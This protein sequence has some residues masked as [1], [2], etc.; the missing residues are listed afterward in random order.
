METF[1]LDTTT[2]LSVAFVYA[3][4]MG[5]TEMVKRLLSNRITNLM[6]MLL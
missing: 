1:P 2:L 3:L 4:V 5:L 6:I